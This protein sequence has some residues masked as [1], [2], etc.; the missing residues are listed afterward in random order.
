MEKIQLNPNVGLTRKERN[1]NTER[2][3][4]IEGRQSIER[5]NWYLKDQKNRL[6]RISNTGKKKKYLCK[7]IL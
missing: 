7:S 6:S 2:N 1:G 4:P 5:E 3:R